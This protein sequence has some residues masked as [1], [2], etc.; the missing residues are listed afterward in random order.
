MELVKVTTEFYEDCARYG[1][2]ENNQL[3]QSEAGR[4]CVLILSLKYRGKRR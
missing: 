4:P 1:A 3:L 2:N